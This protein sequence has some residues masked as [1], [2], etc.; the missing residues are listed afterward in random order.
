MKEALNTVLQKMERETQQRIRQL[1]ADLA[2]ANNKNEVVTREKTQLAIQVGR[3]INK[4][5]NTDVLVSG[6]AREE[7]V[8]AR[9]G[10]AVNA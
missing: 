3:L 2:S 7:P 8:P 5:S 10:Q 6:T 1:E 9:G 4:A